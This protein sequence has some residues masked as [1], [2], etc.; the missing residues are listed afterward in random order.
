MQ[1]VFVHIPKTGG[2]AV[3]EALIRARPD[4]PVLLDYGPRHR[5]TSE[6]VKALRY[7]PD[8]DVAKLCERLRDMPDF[9]FSGHIKAKHYYRHLGLGPFVTVLRHP[10]DRVISHYLHARH[11]QG[12]AGSLIDFASAPQNRDV[13]PRFVGG[14]RLAGWSFVARYER[15]ETDMRRLSD[16]IEAPVEVEP[17]NVTPDDWR[18]KVSVAE[19][20]RIASL[21]PRGM[22][23]YESIAAGSTA[24]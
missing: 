4:A 8:G 12:F 1:I 15:L 10:V 19:R 20:E 24:P 3:R 5:S 7:G 18:L 22:R 2:T 16:L 6:L 13:Q 11:R 9:T 14:D 17:A 23:L 21:N